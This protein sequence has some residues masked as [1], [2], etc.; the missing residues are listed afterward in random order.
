M[1]FPGSTTEGG[2]S[3]NLAPDTCWM[4]TP[5]TP[6]G[7]TAPWP[8]MAD[9]SSAKKTTTKVYI[10]GKKC[11]VEG[12]FIPSSKGN[13]GG[14]NSSIPNGKKGVKSMKNTGKCEMAAH[15]GKVKM[16]GKGVVYHTASTKQNNANTMGKH[17]DSSQDVVVIAK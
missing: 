9:H 17:G 14:C 3:M 12:S 8:N 7:M 1:R 16:Q 2:K 10:R 5:S 13:E 4:P 6:P 15:S 11:L